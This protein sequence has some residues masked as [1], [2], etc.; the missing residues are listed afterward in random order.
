MKKYI[1]IVLAFALAGC[2]SFLDTESYTKKNTSNFPETAGDVSQMLTA[3]YSTLN[4]GVGYGGGPSP[5]TTHFYTAEMA[6][7]DRFGGGG[8]ADRVFQ[9]ADKLMNCAPSFFEPLWATHYEGIFRA[10]M[11]LETIDNTTGWA[12]DNEKNQVKGEAYFMR[13]LL[14]FQLSQMFGE[15]PL[16][17]T[18]EKQNIPQTPYEQTYAQIASDMKTAIEI[19]P[20]R[21]YDPSFSGHATKHV[22]QAYMARIF[23]FYTGYYGKDS[24]PLP[25]SGSVTKSQVVSWLE[26][27]ISGSGHGLVSDFR[28]L[29]PYSNEYTAPDYPY[30]ADNNLRWEGDVNKEVVFA[31]K[32]SNL[33]TWG[34]IGYSNQFNLYFGF[35]GNNGDADTFPFGQGWGCGPVNSTLWEEWAATEPNDIRRVASILD[36]N[37]ELTNYNWGE[38]Q[39]VEE[40]GYWQK[41]YASIRARRPD[42]GELTYYPVLVSGA[43]DNFQLCHT[44]D[45]ILM[46]F[47]DVLL[48]HSELTE[49]ADGINQ[50]RTRVG[51]PSVAYSLDALKRER[52]WEL[53]FEGVRWFD[54]LRWGDAAD[55][56]A[57]QEGVKIWNLGQETTMKAF[58][59]GYR[60]RFEKTKGFWP[61]PQSQIDLSDGVLKQN[62]GWGTPEA[63][64]TG[65]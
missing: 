3:V 44:Q 49:T 45:L 21:T 11:L 27:C 28:N 65:W 37:A 63:E 52:R 61:I 58:G 10:N 57:A 47:A 36:V 7:D 30:A 41:K 15:V 38:S 26:D 51:L 53:A 40:T 20:A 25:D 33:A 39:Q 54:L 34:N 48:M 13:A 50:V 46:R 32:F 56:L 2:E 23:L 59:G 1:I 64:Y 31:L 19:M 55:K 16:I 14:Y 6:S 12:N 60:A 9:V 24:L 8:D 22:A 5:N 43:Q 17:L 29:W 62:E 4:R 42:S 18:T 35:R